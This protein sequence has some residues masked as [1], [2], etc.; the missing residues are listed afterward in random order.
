VADSTDDR[1]RGPEV[2]RV[3]LV[4][5]RKMEA[6][7]VANAVAILMGQLAHLE[8]RLYRSEGVTDPDGNRHAGI[9]FDTVVL[10]GRNA[11]LLRLAAAARERDLSHA[12]FSTVGRGLSNQFTA[13]RDMVERS[14]AADLGICA[15]GVA[16]CDA[17]VRELTRSFSSYRGS[18]GPVATE[19]AAAGAAP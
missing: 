8:P 11:Q 17:T 6:P 9:R 4:V 16:G 5:D 14:A 2:L 1:D 13:Y 3:A 18:G 15:V 19:A 12:V 10:T 7:A